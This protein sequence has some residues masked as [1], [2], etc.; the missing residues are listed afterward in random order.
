MHKV[1][2]IVQLPNDYGDMHIITQY[3][4]LCIYV[5]MALVG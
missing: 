2:Y 3:G 4:R 1:L 5:V